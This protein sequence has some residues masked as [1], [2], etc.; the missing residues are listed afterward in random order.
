M[1][2]D[3]RFRI[4][5]EDL[6]PSD[7]ASFFEHDLPT[8]L[9]ASA[10]TMEPALRWLDLA[11]LTIVVDDTDAWN[12]SVDGGV[13]VQRGRAAAGAVV[14]LTATQVSDLASDQATFMGFF[15]W[16]TLDQRAGRLEQ[17]LDWW[18]VLRGALDG[19]AV[20]LPG[21][22]TFSD[23]DGEPLDLQRSF[24]ADDDPE[25]MRSFLEEAGFLHIRGVFDEGEMKVL[26]DEIDRCASEYAPDDGRSWWATTADGSERLVRQYMLEQHSSAAVELL[27][28]DRFL[29]LAQI[30]GNGHQSAKTCQALTKPIGIVSGISDVPWHKDC[31]LGRHSYDCCGMT[32]GISVTGADA[33]VRSAASHRRIAPRARVAG[34][35]TQ[36]HR[37]SGG[38]PAH[39]DRRR[40]GA[41]V[42]HDPHV[43]ATDRA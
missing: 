28:D 42:V 39:E 41:P 34:V 19:R 16:G 29:R 13:V 5:G 43:A 2:V 31:G 17:L 15:T 18:L 21:T 6:P 36:G 25:M 12:L 40:D 10:D 24:A 33:I 35:L 9:D 14:H 37:P 11:P 8:A 27:D 32:V 1:G 3:V 22:I 30:T 26:D 7:P 38:R 20:Y 4:D 23:P